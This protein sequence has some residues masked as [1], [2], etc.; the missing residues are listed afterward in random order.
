MELSDIFKTATAYNAAIIGELRV[1][2]VGRTTT[3]TSGA[4]EG[5]TDDSPMLFVEGRARAVP[6]NE[7]ELYTGDADDRL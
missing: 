1:V 6:F 3:T 7:I 5:V 2:V 4:F